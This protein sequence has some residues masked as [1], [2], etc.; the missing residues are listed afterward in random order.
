[1][2]GFLQHLC[3]PG[4]RCERA[5]DEFTGGIRGWATPSRGDCKAHE[6][7][8]K[9]VDQVDNIAVVEVVAAYEVT[10][11]W[12]DRQ[13]DGIRRGQQHPLRV[14]DCRDIHG[15]GRDRTCHHA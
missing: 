13:A 8:L 9:L 2:G 6:P 10:L 5:D 3:L 1:M 14:R 7:T 4:P 12:G 15:H 11:D